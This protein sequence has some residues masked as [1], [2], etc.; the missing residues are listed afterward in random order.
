MQFTSEHGGALLI[1][2]I[3]NQIA[4][5]GGYHFCP[6]TDY[7]PESFDQRGSV[8]QHSSYAPGA[9][10]VGTGVRQRTD[11][12]NGSFL[13]EW[14][15]T[16]ILQ[17]HKALRS[18]LT[19]NGTVFFGENLLLGTIHVAILIRIVKQSQLIL[20]FQNTAAGGVDGSC[21]Y[22]AFL[23][24]LLQSAAEGIAHHIH[25]H[26][27]IQGE[28]GNSLLVTHAVV[29]HLVDTG[30]VRYHKPVEIPLLAQHIGHQPLAS[31]GRH[32]VH[33]VERSHYAADTCLDCGL[34][35]QHVFIEHTL[36]AHIHRIIIAP[37]L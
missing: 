13:A 9:R 16:F 10:H 25:I 28:G 34:V 32:T 19:G 21:G 6:V 31:G 14:Q 27:G 29:Y 8:I 2:G 15:H 4:S 23:H 20:R 35:G 36:A 26:P 33:F 3:A 5:L 1:V 11:Y 24:R 18:S 30:I 17:Q 37:R 22:F 12:G 7:F